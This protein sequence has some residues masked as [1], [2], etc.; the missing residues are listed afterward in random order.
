MLTRSILLC[1]SKDE[2]NEITVLT[3][4][5]VNVTMYKQDHKI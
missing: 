3:Y 2:A 1:I 5:Q 4:L